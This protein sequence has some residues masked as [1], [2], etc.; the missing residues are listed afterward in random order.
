[1]VPPPCISST[2]S[3][4]NSLPP[5]AFSWGT[6]L[7]T[8]CPLTDATSRHHSPQAAPLS[9]SPQPNPPSLLSQSV[10]GGQP[11]GWVAQHTE[12]KNTCHTSMHRIRVDMPWDGALPM[13]RHGPLQLKVIA[14]PVPPP[15]FSSLL[16]PSSCSSLSVLHKSLGLSFLVPVP[17][18]LFA[19][20]LLPSSFPLSHSGFLFPPLEPPWRDGFGP[21]AAL[22]TA[23]RVCDCEHVCV[24]ASVWGRGWVGAPGCVCVREREGR[25]GRNL[26]QLWET[27]HAGAGMLSTQLGVKHKFCPW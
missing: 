25:D 18:L 16:L 10:T 9:T 27:V 15:L 5:Q 13:L 23:L 4:F 21:A 3:T 1:M 14:F 2:L 7:L 22:L 26:Q 20:R 6:S 8:Y 12:S 11:A 19:P 17:A 24:Y